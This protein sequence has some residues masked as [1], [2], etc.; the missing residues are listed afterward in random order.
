M[1]TAANYTPDLLFGAIDYENITDSGGVVT[2]CL[3][4]VIMF[5]ISIDVH[6]GGIQDYMYITISRPG[7]C[8]QRIHTR[9][10]LLQ[11][12]ELS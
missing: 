12:F 7:G 8:K 1:F 2:E 6:K 10:I 11:I 4:E 3:F 9:F 5:P